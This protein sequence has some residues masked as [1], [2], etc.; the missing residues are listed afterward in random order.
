MSCVDSN[1]T[2]FTCD[3]SVLFLALPIG[4]TK[5]GWQ[6]HCITLGTI[7]IAINVHFL[8]DDMTKPISTEVHGIVDYSTSGLLI[9]AP[10]LFGYELDSPEAIVPMSLGALTIGASMMTDY[11][12]GMTP[13]ISMKTHLTI[14]VMNGLFLAASPFIFGFYKKSAMNWL[15]HVILGVGEVAAALLTETRTSYDVGQPAPKAAGRTKLQGY[16]PHD[17]NT[18]LQSIY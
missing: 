1:L 5:L 7:D 3:I 13:V 9:G 4:N 2:R 14:D 18:K 8:E 12:L 11:E 10:F 15:P 17:K 6:Y 16:Q